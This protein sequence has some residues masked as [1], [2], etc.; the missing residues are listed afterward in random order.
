MYEDQAGRFWIGTYG[1]GLELLDREEFIFTHYSKEAGISND[2][3]YGILEDQEGNLWMSTNQ[4]L[5][6]FHPD[7]REVRV[8][9][10][11]DGIQGK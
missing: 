11:S 6:R 2:A 5:L 10:M 1:G 8:F 4:G 7:T 3:I 9:E